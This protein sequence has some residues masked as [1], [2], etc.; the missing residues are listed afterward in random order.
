MRQ[1]VTLRSPD[2]TGCGRGYESFY[3][4]P[5]QHHQLGTKSLDARAC[6]GTFHHS[7]QLLKKAVCIHA[8]T[9][10]TCQGSRAKVTCCPSKQLSLHSLK[11]LLGRS[12]TSLCSPGMEFILQGHQASGLSRCQDLGSSG[13]LPPLI[14]NHI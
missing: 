6:G 1:L 2:W 12:P 3:N 13:S 8:N 14:R 10:Y 11:D 7:T 5:K 4:L 9:S